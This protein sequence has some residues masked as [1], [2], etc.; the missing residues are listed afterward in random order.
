MND[1]NN[2]VPVEAW[3]GVL[4]LFPG[5]RNE[6]GRRLG[7]TRQGLANLR[8]LAHH[9][10]PHQLLRKLAKLLRQPADGSRPPTQQVLTRKW[11]AAKAAAQ[12]VADAIDNAKGPD[13]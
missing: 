8:N 1:T 2:N 13:R 7:L 11:L 3:R 6:L 9:T 4:L 5:T 12:R 10:A